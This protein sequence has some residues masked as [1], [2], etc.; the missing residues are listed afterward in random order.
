MRTASV[1]L[2]GALLVCGGCPGDDAEDAG[3]SG[4]TGGT[5]GTTAAE[6]TDQS[7]DEVEDCSECA[8]DKVCVESDLGQLYCVAGPGTEVE[9]CSECPADQM[10]RYVFNQRVCVAIP[11]VCE[12]TPSCDCLDESF[13]GACRLC[14][15]SDDGFGCNVDCECEPELCGDG[16]G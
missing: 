3:G 10:C 7:L 1:A 6:V 2:A 12:E 15:V 9:A 16:E 11:S 5:P 4:A 8:Q 13:C 14:V